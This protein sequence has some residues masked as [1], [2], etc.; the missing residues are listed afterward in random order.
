MSTECHARRD[1][2]RRCAV[3]PM[4]R[5][6]LLSAEP[7]T[8]E[9]RYSEAFPP[10][11]SGARVA[12]DTAGNFVA[13]WTG[14]EGQSQ[15]GVYFQRFNPGGSELTGEV[16]VAGGS[17]PDVAVG[18]DGSFVVA[19]RVVSDPGTDPF[20]FTLFAQRFSAAGQPLTGAVQVTP[21][22]VAA[23][24][25]EGGVL[26]RVATDA[27]G[28]FVVAWQQ[29][30]RD[31]PFRRQDVFARRFSG[32]GVAEGNVFRV[33][34]ASDSSYYGLS[35]AM[36]DAGDSVVTWSGNGP[37]D[38]SGLGVFA[39][40]YDAAGVPQGGEFL[41]NVT[42][43]GN[44]GSPTVSAYADGDFVV[45]W[46][47]FPN[48]FPPTGET[49]TVFARRFGAD[50]TPQTGEIRVGGGPAGEHHLPIVAVER[51]G[52]RFVV[53]WRLSRVMDSDVLVQC[54]DAA[55]NKVGPELNP[56]SGPNLEY[57]SPAG[58]AA[59]PGGH[60]V[61]TWGPFLRVFSESLLA[62]VVD[63]APDPAAG[64]VESA[65]IRFREPVTGLDRAT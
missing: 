32:A 35:V 6:L 38:P 33:N 19:W 59:G 52:G 43:R 44:Q 65:T 27:E 18:R 58:V 29:Q 57:E 31:D 21:S 50:G 54:F 62:D 20:T 17:A 63:V 8:P 5:R 2:L 3:E 47:D 42:T 45:A 53:A 51:D 25:A 4:E 61:A 26:P 16:R 28:D 23:V 39:R 22:P 46:D 36:G 37:A 49:P 7:V 64:P 34:D 9:F 56:R 11:D 41:A 30:R 48:Q 10:T 55:G 1:R 24:T 13:A 12:A 14:R 40:R 15:F 60:F